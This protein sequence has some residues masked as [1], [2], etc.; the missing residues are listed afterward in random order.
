MPHTSNAY[1]EHFYPSNTTS[2]KRFLT[3]IGRVTVIKTLLI[4]KL[5]HLFISKPNPK[6]EIIS[7]SCKA[8][9]E[10]LWNSKVYKVRKQDCFSGSLKM[11]DINSCIISL[12]CTCNSNKPW[13]DMFL[14][15]MGRTPLYICTRDMFVHQYW[16]NRKKCFLERWSTVM[17]MLYEGL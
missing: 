6:M 8:M 11:V 12:T 14:L 10:F 17:I 16:L 1:I 2:K 9:F 3:P 13:L 15:L 7:L 4:P 5:N